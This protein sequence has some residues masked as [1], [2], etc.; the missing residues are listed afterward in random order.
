M[1]SFWF[2][3][4]RGETNSNE[5]LRS[6]WLPPGIPEETRRGSLVDY[7]QLRLKGSETRKLRN[8]SIQVKTPLTEAG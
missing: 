3:P 5:G 6:V 1:N 8:R 4:A 2:C 7:E